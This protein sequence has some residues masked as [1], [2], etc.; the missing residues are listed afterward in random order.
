MSLCVLAAALALP[1]PPRIAVIGGGIGGAASAHFLSKQIPGARIVIFERES[2]VGGRLRHIEHDGVHVELGG[3]FINRRLNPHMAQLIDAVNAPTESLLPSLLLQDVYIYNGTVQ[4]LRLRHE[5]LIADGLRALAEYG[6]SAIKT[7]DESDRFFTALEGMQAR[8]KRGDTFDDISELLEWTGLA[9]YARVSTTDLL[10]PKGVSP[11]FLSQIISAFT[12][13]I[14]TQGNAVNA[15]VSLSIIS[16]FTRPSF[17]AT[18][19][20]GNDA[21]VRALIGSSNATLRLRSAVSAV[22]AGSGMVR[23]SRGGDRSAG[24]TVRTTRDEA[25]DLVVVATPLESSSLAFPGLDLVPTASMRRTYVGVHVTVLTSAR[26]NGTFFGNRPGDKP[27]RPESLVMAPTRSSLPRGIHFVWRVGDANTS[28]SAAGSTAQR[29][30]AAAGGEAKGEGAEGVYL[31]HSAQELDGSLIS[32]AFGGSAR[33]V[34]RHYWPAAYPVEVPTVSESA[35]PPV[36]L[37]RYN[38]SSGASPPLVYLN[39]L[40]SLESAMETS[41]LAANNAARLLARWWAAHGG[42]GSV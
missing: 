10:Q 31:I 32:L 12:N 30:G 8:L 37:N 5:H 39:A 34:V 36:I 13:V 26:L 3:T 25:F 15:F 1:P 18:T 42:R 24:F 33:H 20:L 21:L 40:E 9:P 28:V 11:S 19:T 4:A 38:H 7:V 2:T 27:M 41:A 35:R 23:G 17:P 22:A 6:L 29:A 14:Y 16:M